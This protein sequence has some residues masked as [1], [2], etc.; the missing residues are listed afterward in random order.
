MVR[1]VSSDGC[2]AKR[3]ILMAASQAMPRLS[4]VY[5]ARLGIALFLFFLALI[6]VLA[7][8]SLLAGEND[9]LTDTG[10]LVVG[11]LWLVSAVLYAAAGALLLRRPPNGRALVILGVAL[12]AGGVLLTVNPYF[13]APLTAAAVLVAV[14][15]FAR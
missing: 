10:E 4:D 12:V 9:D 11:I 6:G 2:R 7:G 13:G 15:G 3:G 14:L 1:P 5:A 8:I